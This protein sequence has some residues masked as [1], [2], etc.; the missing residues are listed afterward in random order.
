[1]LETAV[2]CPAKLSQPRRA[3]GG[4]ATSIP[5]VL[6]LLGMSTLRPG[7]CPHGAWRPKSK[8]IH[9]SCH[10]TARRHTAMHPSHSSTPSQ[11]IARMLRSGLSHIASA[12]MYHRLAAVTAG[13]QAGAGESRRQPPFCLVS[14]STDFESR[15]QLDRGAHAAR[16]RCPC[17]PCARAC[18][19]RVDTAERVAHVGVAPQFTTL[20]MPS[21]SHLATCHPRSVSGCT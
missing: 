9:A 20:R 1:M 15:A 3:D 10:Q 4:G 13:E 14:A 6:C 12:E 5:H 2:R 19:G 18:K 16:S 21:H 7:P 11:C 17:P 8:S